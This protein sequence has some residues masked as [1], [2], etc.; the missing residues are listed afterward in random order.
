MLALHAI[1]NEETNKIKGLNYHMIRYILDYYSNLLSKH[2]SCH[3][4]DCT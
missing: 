4:V 3:K 2:E 1:R